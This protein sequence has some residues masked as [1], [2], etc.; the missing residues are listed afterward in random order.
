M[1][2]NIKKFLEKLAQDEEAQ[3]K[4]R[5]TTDPDEAYR[6]ASALQDGF[7]KEEF[8]AAMEELAKEVRPN[9]INDSDLND[10]AGG[11]D[12]DI[13]VAVTV[14]AGVG[15]VVTGASVVVALSAAAI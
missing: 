4:F 14:G 10:L 6:I 15:G 7:T 3:A 9:E 2:E 11:V 12:V 13:N 1:N 8:V 5:A